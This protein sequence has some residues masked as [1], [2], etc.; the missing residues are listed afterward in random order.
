M[1]ISNR[2][3]DKKCDSVAT[4]RLAPKLNNGLFY[5]H[6]SFFIW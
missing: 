2:V 4:W 6:L 3:N 1:A 5:L